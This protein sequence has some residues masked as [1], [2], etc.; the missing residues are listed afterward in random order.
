L[1]SR[2][3][4]NFL[5]RDLLHGVSYLHKLLTSCDDSCGWNDMQG[6]RESYKMY[7]QH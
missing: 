6:N 2:E 7:E 5:R 1:S 3:T 4:V